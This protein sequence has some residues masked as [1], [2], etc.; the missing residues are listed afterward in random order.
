MNRLDIEKIDSASKRSYCNA[1]MCMQLANICVLYETFD[2]SEQ[3]TKEVTYEFE[4]YDKEDRATGIA[5]AW[6]LI[7]KNQ[8]GFD[9]WKFARNMPYIQKVKLAMIPKGVHDRIRTNHMT[10]NVEQAVFTYFSVMMW[11]LKE[12]CGF[13]SDDFERYLDGF[14]DICRLFAKGMNI[15]F[16]AE[17]VEKEIGWKIV[18]NNGEVR[19]AL[20]GKYVFGADRG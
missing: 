17:F 12:F 1:Y 19:L 7:L 5:A 3:K 4:K 18:R 8:F 2:F 15:K 10:M 11:T 14:F 16:M 13:A 6:S 9:C 20:D